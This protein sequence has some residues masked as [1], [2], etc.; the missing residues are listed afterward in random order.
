MRIQLRGSTRPR[1]HQSLRESGGSPG[2]RRGQGQ[3]AVKFGGGREIKRLT[4]YLWEGEQ[5]ERMTAGAYGKGTGLVILTDRRL[6]FLQ[7]EIM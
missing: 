1:A 2:H 7:H 5:V 6:L 3:D 4:E